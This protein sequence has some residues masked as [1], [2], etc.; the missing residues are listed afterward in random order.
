MQTSLPISRSH[1]TIDRY[2]TTNHNQKISDISISS[3]SKFVGVIGRKNN[4]CLSVSV[5][6]KL[7]LVPNTHITNAWA[8]G[9]N[10]HV[11][12]TFQFQ[13]QSS[14]ANPKDTPEKLLVN[15]ILQTPSCR[16]E[17]MESIEE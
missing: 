1:K 12:T 16:L 5:C 17:I 10:T 15:I 13:S 11:R 2:S 7:L 3:S 8:L 9:Q 14:P 4:I 6:S